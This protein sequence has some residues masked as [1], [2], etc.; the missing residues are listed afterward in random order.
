[1]NETADMSVAGQDDR[2]MVLERQTGGGHPIIVRTRVNSDVHEF[3][4]GNHITTVFCD[5]APE[6]VNQDHMPVC[7]GEL[8]DFEDRLVGL[9]AESGKRAHHTASATGAG[10]RAIY[11]TH[12]ADVEIAALAAS[13]PFD[14]GQVRADDGMTFEIYDGLVW[15]TI[16]DARLDN[17]RRV[18]SSLES[19][20]DVGDIPRKIDFFFY[21]E[22]PALEDV[23]VRLAGTGMVIDHWTNDEGTGLA[24]AMVAPATFAHFSALTPAILHAL[25]SASVDYDGWGCPVIATPIAEPDPR[26]APGFM[27]RLFGKN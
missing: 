2:W 22:R 16:L 26:P 12:A 3:A 17:D 5:V 10:V 18:L 14:V 13:V 27:K 8:Y 19:H 23:A 1:M 21:G 24:M 6:L 9:V 25:Q 15:P 4:R 7:M 11:F 20:G